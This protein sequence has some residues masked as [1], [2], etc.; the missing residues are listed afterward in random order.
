MKRTWKKYVAVA[1]MVLVLGLAAVIAIPASAEVKETDTIPKRVY[2]DEISVGG[3][4]QEEA[5]AAVEEYMKGIQ[6]Q[7]ITISAG[8]NTAQIPVSQLGV[9]WS[10]PEIVKEAAGLG[11]SGN[12]IARYKAMKD[13]ENEDRVYNLSF[14]V[15][16][17]KVEQV[18]EANA[19]KLNT[20]AKDAS[21]A[22]EN[23]GFNITPG[24][25]GVTVNIEKSL[26]VLNAYFAK[27]WD[28]GS[29][30]VEL[31]ADVVD[32]RGTEEEFAKVKDLLGSF[33]TSYSSSGA[34]RSKNVENGANLING[35][36]LYPGDSFSVYEAVSPFDAEHGYELAG[37]Y[38]NG[39]TVET[40]GGGI[41]QVSTTLYNAVIRAELEVTERSNHSMI[42][43]YVDPSADA[44]IAGT[45]KDLK[46]V[47]N[48]DAPIYIEGYTADRQLYFNIF[49]Q[50]T[51]P[52]NREVSFVSETLST[53]QPG[54]QYQAA[55][56]RPIG[57]IS[58]T[59]SSHTGYTAQL[60]K[61]VTVDGVEE[62]REVFNKSSYNASPTIIQVGTASGN[63]S[64]VGA[65]N[66]A[67]GSQ[68][69][70]AIDAA[71]AQW[72]DAALAAAAAAQQ[73]AEAEAA[74]AAQQN[75]EGQPPQEGQEGEGEGNKP[76]EGGKPEEGEGPA[77]QEP[78]EEGGGQ[79]PQ[80]P[81]GQEGAEG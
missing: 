24:S 46:F 76:E 40:Y 50:E 38:E 33:H 27:E 74:A 32:P 47:N 68:N 8:K 4:T 21:L 52:A 22:R 79:E 77:D 31:V 58:Q 75:P 60:W 67:I 13:L 53:T 42:V 30:T 41:C 81:E 7:T 64:A 28:G 34:G 62:S 73:Q 35:A 17:Q 2:F 15:D 1:S 3:M 11:K 72:N 44:A 71:I 56:G 57:Y 48:T 12:L 10:N 6:S 25:Q 80:P 37:S 51:R 9:T 49:G 16:S 20:E 45:Y 5:E 70:G 14:E 19:P 66:A 69:R 55:P 54:V 59:Q 29:G 43:N 61:V 78:G 23:G 26:E 39:T 65:M 36:L 63:P 18:L